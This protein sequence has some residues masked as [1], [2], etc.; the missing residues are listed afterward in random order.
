MGP[1]LFSSTYYTYPAFKGIT[2]LDARRTP[3]VLTTTRSSSSRNSW[4]SRDDAPASSCPT[5][6]SSG[7]SVSTTFDL[8]TMPKYDQNLAC[9]RLL[10]TTRDPSRWHGNATDDAD[11]E[12]TARLSEPKLGSE[13]P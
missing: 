7:I 6:R 12:S 11:E 4:V 5:S 2:T 1:N 3:E 10:P 13:R 9:G 8:D